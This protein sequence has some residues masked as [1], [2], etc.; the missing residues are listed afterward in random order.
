MA[1][2]IEDKIRKQ[3]EFYFSDSNYPRD[4]FLRA[5]ASLDEEGYVPLSVIS[6]FTRIKNLTT[7][8]NLIAAALKT[9]EVVQVNTDGT[10]VRRNTPLPQ[11]DLSSKKSIYAKGFP[12]GTTID[13]ITAA[14]DPKFKVACVRI[15][16]TLD[17]KPKES[18]FIEF[19]TVDEA[20]AAVESKPKFQDKDLLVYLK[21]DYVE[22]KKQEHKQQKDAKGEGEGSSN[23]NAEGGG[24]KKRK[25][26][27]ERPLEGS[28]I[29]FTGLG[30]GV[31]REALKSA[32]E[33]FGEIAFV[34]YFRDQETGYIRFK[35]Q[36]DAKKAADAAAAEPIEVVGKKMTV[37]L[38]EGDQLKE[39]HKK[40][41]IKQKSRAKGGGFKGKRGGHKKQKH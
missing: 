35:G 18:A 24:G 6:T 7:D 26:E 37:T 12:V 29:H 13:D 2:S 17:K 19:S 38:V 1:E 36:G 8:L 20:K 33:K 9:S 28:I 31:D 3:V 27:E 21:N 34:D 41:Q 10:K 25:V 5:Q 14:F 11:E 22:M 23:N 4:K 40:V 32:F 15:R 30:Q 39:Y 16:K